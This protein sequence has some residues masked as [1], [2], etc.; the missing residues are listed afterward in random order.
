MKNHIQE[1]LVD[2]LREISDS[3]YKFIQQMNLPTRM[4][5][6]VIKNFQKWCRILKNR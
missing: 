4:L 1:K 2:K 3:Q 6:I 5:F